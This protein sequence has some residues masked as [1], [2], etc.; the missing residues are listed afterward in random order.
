MMNA[1]LKQLLV[2][3]NAYHIFP[4]NSH[5]LVTILQRKHGR[6]I[7]NLNQLVLSLR[8]IFLDKKSNIDVEIVYFESMTY[9]EQMIQVRRSNVFILGYGAAS[10]YTM[11][12]HPG[13]FAISLFIH[14][15]YNTFSE[16]AKEISSFS[17][18]NSSYEIVNDPDAIP[19][20]T[21][22]ILRNTLLP[23]SS[24]SKQARLDWEAQYCGNTITSSK[25]NC[26]QYY[27][28]FSFSVS[29]PCIE[30]RVYEL[31]LL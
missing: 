11:F 28:S 9:E 1:Y 5:K 3:N 29:I 18:A 2:S 27:L 25:V 16:L 23:D 7:L 15:T 10:I 13:T 14:E 26:V 17:Q 20:I 4:N 24:F 31:L 22:P 12:M 30:Q 21:L 8:K 6:V 19:D